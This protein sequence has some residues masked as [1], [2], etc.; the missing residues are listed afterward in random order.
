[1]KE[2]DRKAHWEQVYRTKELEEVG[3]YQPI[4]K[5][6]LKFFKDLKVPLDSRII[7]V[8]GGDS[9]LADYL[10]ELGYHDITVLDISETAIERAKNRLGENSAKIKW[11][12]ADA[13]HFKPQ[14]K[15]DFWHDRAAFH[16]MTEEKDISRYV[17]TVQRHIRS[18]GFLVI[19]TFSEQGPETCSGLRIKQYSESTLTG[20]FREHFDKVK[21]ITLDH[22][23]P[24]GTLQNYVFCGFRRLPARQ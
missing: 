2:F 4:P 17:S 1:M 5:T 9:F 23:T 16:F 19:G 8:G 22:K 6:S 3:W 7:D 18:G 14:R 10:L 12:V 20:L 15:Y 24:S 21:C 11:V 13:A